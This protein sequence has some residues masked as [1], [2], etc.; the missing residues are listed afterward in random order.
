MMGFREEYI[1]Y[2]SAVRRYSPRTCEIY[3]GV[4]DGYVRFASEC[5][6]PPEECE[7][8]DRQTIRSYEV[9]LME[10]KKQCAGT[11]NLHL[12]VLSGYCRFLVKKGVLDANPVRLV[13][14]PKQEKRLPVFYR[15]DAMDSYFEQSAHAAGP[16]ELEVLQA[17]T[18]RQLAEELYERRLRR[19]IVSILYNTGMRR[20]E[21][22]GLDISSV[23][24]SRHTVR[25]LGKGNKIREIPVLPS[26]CEEISLYLQAT[27]SLTEAPQGPD[28][29][30]LRTK[31]G[32]RLYPVF[33]DRAIKKELGTVEDITSRKSPHVLRHTLAS[34][35][36][37][38]GA[39]LGS[40]K[41]L[42]GHSSLAATQVYTHTSVERLQ[43]IYESAHPRAKNGN[44]NGD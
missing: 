31:S 9:H 30:L 44:K 32:G 24:F 39:E 18:S 21:L 7:V 2:I 38:D 8:P 33:V 35:L 40:I 25:V 37:E 19:L 27:S 10:R 28:T 42:L 41:E 36:L 6:I 22:I 16:D 3:A 15:R 34:E 29:P 12:S 14:R 5:G 1:T 17:A 11:V 20:S 23:D 4:L 43:K 26:L 13:T